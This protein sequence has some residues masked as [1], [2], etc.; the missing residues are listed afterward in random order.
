M[1]EQKC[2]EWRENMENTICREFLHLWNALSRE[3]TC[4]RN[5]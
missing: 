2:F 3:K 5:G 1:K 4:V